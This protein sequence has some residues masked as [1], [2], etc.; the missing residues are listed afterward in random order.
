MSPTSAAPHIDNDAG[1]FIA[2]L[3]A[4]AQRYLVPFRGGH[5]A[6][7]RFGAGPAL[8]LLH[9]GHGRWLH[10]ARNIRAWATRHTVWV[11][12]LPGYGESDAPPEPT[13]AS[14]VAVT[15]DTLD[16]LVGHDEPVALAGFSFGGLVAA[17]MA[18]ITASAAAAG[19]HADTD[20]IGQATLSPAARRAPFT[21]LALLGTGGHGGVRR[22]RGALR[23]WREAAA[24]HDRAGLAEV[25]RHNLLMHMLHEAASVDAL[26]LHIHT[27]ACLRTRFHS[28]SISLAGGLGRALDAYRGPLLLAWG[29]HDVTA[30]PEAVT[31]ILSAGREGCRTRILPGAGHWLPYERSEEINPWVLA[32]LNDGQAERPA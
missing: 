9:G 1:A 22:P 3:E 4:E 13:L 11:P 18:A 24:R 6:W 8:V 19:T 31:P 25:M 16:A 30:D 20:A 15:M 17:T 7:R 28:K 12:D 21:H 23:P 26:A 5:V 14:L 27:D 10:W 32:W 2:A 29:E